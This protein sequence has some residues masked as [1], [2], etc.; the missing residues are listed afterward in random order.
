M[1]TNSRPR[2]LSIA[3]SDSG[4]GAGVQADLK[5]IT[6]LGGYG[7]SAITAIT[8]QNT[9]GV[10]ESLVLEPT[11]VRA[12]IEAVVSDIGVDVVK[13]GMLGTKAMI[14]TIAPLLEKLRVPFVLDP[15]MVAKGGAS[16]LARDAVFAMQDKLVPFCTV[17]TPNIPEAEVLAG[18]K[19]HTLDHMR[20][21][22]GW[23]LDMGAQA[24]LLK[25]G[26]MQGDALSDLL[27]WEGGEAV[28][29]SARIDTPHTHGTGCTLASAI[30]CGL[31][32]GLELAQA[33]KQAR[34]YVRQ[35][36][37]AAPG[38]GAGH[39]PMD[40]GWPCNGKRF[41]EPAKTV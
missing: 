20:Q 24:V 12:Q 40:H 38:F 8:A 1:T 35:A 41:P 22:A 17:I 5:T 29:T 33:V 34:D 7:M 37:L 27:L 23:L 25:G 2:I 11:L 4:G 18:M 6:A 32:Q 3:G 19:I 10:V 14:E 39:G 16:L 26:H 36:I 13:T 30:A 9:L 15:V 28:F 21:A 31:G